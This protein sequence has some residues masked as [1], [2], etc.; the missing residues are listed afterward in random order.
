MYKV[1][2]CGITNREDLELVA[3][4]GADY[5]GALIDLEYSPRS[6][7]LEAAVPIFSHPPLPLVTL[8]F[9]KHV[10][11]NQHVVD[12][13]HP[14]ALQ[15]HGQETPE[16]VSELKQR[17]DCKIWKVIHLPFSEKGEPVDIS[18]IVEDIGDYIRAGAD[19]FLFDAAG[20]VKGQMKFGGT[21]MTVNWEVVKSIKDTIDRPVL[22]AGGINPDNVM[23]ALRAVEAYG[24]DLS[25]GVERTT[26]KKDPEMVRQLIESVRQG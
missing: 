11:E 25:S 20:M 21:G 13:L 22:L 3:R 19:A 12:A 9:N 26:G 24:V 16:V 1:K 6:H 2:I 4:L 8:T 14:V 18:P 10:D 17:C 5:G 7:T 23:E 15:L